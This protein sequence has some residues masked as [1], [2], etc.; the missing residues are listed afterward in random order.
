MSAIFLVLSLRIVFASLILEHSRVRNF[1][2]ASYIHL[3]QLLQK[4]VFQFNF[5][6]PGNMANPQRVLVW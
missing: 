2:T 1:D 3:A 5:L 6:H 4:C